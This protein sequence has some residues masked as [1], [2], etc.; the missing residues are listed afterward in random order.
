MNDRINESRAAEIAEIVREGGA[1][2]VLLTSEVSL[3]Y[4]AGVTAM[5]G[6]CV[7][8]ADGTAYFITD[9]R[10]IEVAEQRIAP[11]GFT[12]ICRR[13]AEALSAFLT[14]IFEEHAVRRLLYED[15]YLTVQEFAGLR[16]NLGT[17]KEF[18]PASRQ[19]AALRACKSQREI[20]CIIRAQRI[21][22]Q[23]LSRL[24]PELYTGITE[25]EAA[26]RLNYYMALG[27]SEKPSFDTIMLFGENTSKPH[28]TP[29][30]R[31]LRPG[32]FITMDFGAVYEGYHSDM[33]RT[34]AY[35]SATDKMREVYETVL[36]AQ[37]AAATVAQAGLRCC[38]MHNAAMN[39]IERAGYGQYFTH[40]LGHTVGLEIHEY[41]IAAPRCEV[42]LR[43]GMVMTDE[44]G[45]YI[46]G[47]FGV[48]IED[49]LVICGGTPQNLTEAPKEF[50]VL[51]ERR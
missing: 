32:D 11:Q 18:L 16:D 38:D 41:P 26:A 24:L 4:A 15:A 14:Q 42:L 46:A 35:G 9:G 7:I 6:A 43:D 37:S 22:E 2:A 21:A 3:I 27:G 10:Y 45:I 19:L 33:T 12:V 29:S 49:M 20:G 5:E 1:D 8:T 31:A 23:A 47:E 40:A 51:P 48:R 28:G 25:R 39:V 50:T 44:P 17:V 36:R 30:D 34:V 13:N